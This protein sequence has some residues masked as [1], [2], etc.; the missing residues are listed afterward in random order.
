MSFPLNI[1]L[2]IPFKDNKGERQKLYLAEIEVFKAQLESRVED[3]KNELDE[4]F[5]AMFE[6]SISARSDG[7]AKKFFWRF[8][9]TKQDRKYNR[10]QADSVVEYLSRVDDKR[11]LRVKEIE[12][13]LIYINANMKLLKGR[14]DSI[15]QSVKELQMLLQA[16]I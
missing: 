1:N 7:S 13:E 12:M 6:L 10:L 16:N 4:I 15:D 11:K 5:G 3:L 14:R 9:S 8:K 2:I